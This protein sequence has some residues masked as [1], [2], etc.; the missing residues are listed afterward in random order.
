MAEQ[1]ADK[2]G[3]LLSVETIT[4]PGDGAELALAAVNNGAERVLCAGGDGTLN[5]VA[6]GLLGTRVPLGIV[7]MGSG[8]GYSRSLGLPQEPGEASK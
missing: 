3:V 7:P 8:N 5:S 6:T 1:L 2:L 4:G